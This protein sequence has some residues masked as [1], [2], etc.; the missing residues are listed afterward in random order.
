V[1]FLNSILLAFVQPELRCKHRRTLCPLYVAWRK[2]VSILHV[3]NN[4]VVQKICQRATRQLI[5]LECSGKNTVADLLDHRGK[6]TLLPI[7]HS[8]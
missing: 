3:T 5:W 1:T 4:V 7:I 8:S 2:V 6:Q